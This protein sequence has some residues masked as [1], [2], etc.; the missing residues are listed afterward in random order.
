MMHPVQTKGGA[1]DVPEEQWLSRYDG[2]S[3]AYLPGMF[4]GRGVQ[5]VF[6]ASPADAVPLTAAGPLAIC[7]GAFR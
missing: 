1:A 4:H 3:N 2:L 5:P 6:R 7:P